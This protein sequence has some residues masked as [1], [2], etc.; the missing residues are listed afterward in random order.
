[1]ENRNGNNGFYRD[2]TWE[3]LMDEIGEIKASQKAM[4]VDIARIK[5]K[6]QWLFGLAA[7]VALAVNVVWQWILAKVTGGK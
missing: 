7:G 5:S 4:A 1:M 2:K 6:L 3:L